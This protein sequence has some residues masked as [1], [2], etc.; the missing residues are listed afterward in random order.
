[1]SK[2][3]ESEIELF[4]IEELERLGYKF[5]NGPDI[6]CDGLFSERQSYADI[7][8]TG[9]LRVA[10][11]KLNPH[12]PADAQEQAVQ[13]VLRIYSPDLLHNNETF[14]QFL[15][16]KVKIPYQQDGYERSYEVALI[17]F[18]HPS[19]NEF[20]AVNQYTVIENNQNKRPD[21]LLFINGIPLVVIELKNAADENATIR[22]AFEQ[23]Q[24]YKATIP[25]LF[26]Y[27]A[28][29]VISDGMECEAGSLSAG[30]SRFMTW[31]STDGEKGAS[32]F[33]PQLEI[34]IKGM[35]N[36]V[37]LLDLV[38][39]FIVFEKSKKEDPKTGIIHVETEKKLAAYHQ[40]YA[41]NKAVENT[42]KAA[43]IDGN[44]KGGVVWH[45]QGSGKSIS[46]V[47]YTGKLVLSLNNPTVV[48]IT[49]RNDLDDQLFDTF[50]SSK[51]L[52][53]QEPIQARDREHLKE[54]LKVASGGIV[55]TTIQKFLPDTGK[56]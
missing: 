43:S 22:K 2:I 50:A 32:R 24:T 28:V 56:A 44:R 29:C 45:T 26:T 15:I 9:R 54:L 51:Q 21:I 17:D 8:L 47:F 48:V 55:F 18:S 36:P 10:I 13:K 7:I 38:R 4:T 11:Q 35:F 42:L 16:E 49:D 25:S 30:F 34:L 23:I 33:I 39:N 52:L 20:L 3:T 5:L 27:N 12:I 1:M 40:Y 6:S 19:N 37:T 41:V 53:R 46:M 14:H 31:K